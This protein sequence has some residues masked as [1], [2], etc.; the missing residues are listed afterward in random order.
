VNMSRFWGETKSCGVVALGR[1]MVL[2]PGN[3]NLEGWPYI[4]CIS[5]RREEQAP[6]LQIREMGGALVVGLTRSVFHYGPI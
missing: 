3:A 2:R 1:R 5:L 6:P 4:R